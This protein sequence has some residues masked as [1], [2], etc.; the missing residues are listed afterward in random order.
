MRYFDASALAKRYVR[1]AGS[2]K[3]R[4]LLSS[5]V[6][7]TCRYSQVAIAGALARR[8]REGLLREDER[9]RA[10]AAPSEDMT[11]LLVAELTPNIVARAQ[12][13]LH[14]YPLRAGDV[15]NWP[16]ASICGTPSTRCV[17]S[18][19]TIVLPMRRGRNNSRWTERPA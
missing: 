14:R 15:S 11:D 2:A 12:A 19:S 6:A 7:A 8:A 4:R 13:L 3:V 18:P 5:E 9:N 10:M 17:W 16:V 1:E